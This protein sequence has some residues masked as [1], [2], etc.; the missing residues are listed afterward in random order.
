[1][2]RDRRVEPKEEL[3]LT[4]VDKTFLK[5]VFELILFEKFLF[6]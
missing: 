5:V 3:I 2:L 1:M 6:L 4:R